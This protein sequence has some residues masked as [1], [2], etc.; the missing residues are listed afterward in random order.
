[1]GIKNG[2]TQAKRTRT[3]TGPPRMHGAATDPKTSPKMKGKTAEPVKAGGTPPWGPTIQ[4]QQVKIS[5]ATKDDEKTPFWGP[6]WKHVKGG[7]CMTPTEKKKE[8][9]PPPQATFNI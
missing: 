1:V 6:Q 2:S 3:E 9:R 4:E 8:R 5:G 7:R